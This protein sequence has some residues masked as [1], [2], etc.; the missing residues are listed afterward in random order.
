MSLL[1]FSWEIH[2]GWTSSSASA[3]IQ[4][5]ILR[6]VISG[7]ANVM[8]FFVISG[9]ALSFKP[10]RLLQNEQHLKMYQVL[11]SSIFR[12]HPRL[13][14]PAVILCSPA[15]IIAYLGG[16]SGSDSHGG[17]GEDMTGAAIK[18]MNP[19]R[20]DSFWEQLG[21]YVT[22]LMSLSDIYSPNGLNWAYSDSLWTLP[23]EFKSSL[24]I[25]GILVAVSRCT[26]RAR[27]VIATSVAFY[28]FWYFHWGEFL[29]I[30][31]MLIVDLS[32]Q[33]RQRSDYCVPA[34]SRLEDAHDIADNVDE[35]DS[36]L[37]AELP[38]RAKDTIFVA[39][40]KSQG[41]CRLCAAIA[42]L[43]GL[44]VLSMPQQG[45]GA[46]DSWGFKTLSAVIPTHFRAGGAADYFWQP[47]AAVFLVVVVNSAG[48]L[49]RIFTTPL[50][51]YLGRISFALY[52][53]HMLIL[54]SLGFWL[55][56]EILALTGSEPGWQYG[57]GIFI[58]GVT[59]G[60]VIIYAADLGARLVDAKVVQFTSWAYGYLCRPT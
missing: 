50:A 53:V 13:F 49:R 52:L 58:A 54:H 22:T 21:H 40:F 43:A 37:E 8:L 4:F 42:F 34:S 9:Y 45:H 1:W 3:L 16:Y 11:A 41:L 57:S 30:G 25:F 46:G 24:V 10:L 35:D 59:V 44:F 39:F 14:I 47:L 23:I 12:R 56:K 19:P 48:F 32:L 20:L 29:F 7:P 36:D 17:G 5:P 60:C 55:G 31:G 15:P 6:L 28:S 2:N 38:R 51:Q 33:L 18:P 26:S 27:I